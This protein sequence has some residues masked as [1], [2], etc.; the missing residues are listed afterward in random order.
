MENLKLFLA[1]SVHPSCTCYVERREDGTISSSDLNVCGFTI[2]AHA[3]A[4]QR[5]T[6]RLEAITLKGNEGELT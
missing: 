3:E 5:L 1:A 4:V 2:A 6:E